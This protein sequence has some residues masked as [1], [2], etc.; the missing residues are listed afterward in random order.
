MFDMAFLEKRLCEPFCSSCF[1]AGS[2]KGK[3]DAAVLIPMLERDG[4]VSLLFTRRSRN[5]VEHAG[6]ISFPGGHKEPEDKSF[7]DTALR[8]T[9]EEI[10][11]KRQNAKIL[12]CLPPYVTL[13]GYRIVPV[14]ARLFAP[15]EF[16][17]QPSEVEEIFEVPLDYLCDDRNWSVR[18][19]TESNGQKLETNSVTYE[20]YCIWG[21]TA[22][23]LEEFKTRLRTVCLDL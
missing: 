21:I 9:I 15:Y 20:K 23:I 14:V 3:T 13:T 2:V 19:F 5:L 8:E 10:S 4:K 7:C 1:F 12:C 18:E 11:L 16:S 17:P 22:G 6:Q